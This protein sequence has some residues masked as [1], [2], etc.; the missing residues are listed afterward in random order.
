MNTES[1]G[2]NWITYQPW[3]DTVQDY[4]TGGLGLL[5]WLPGCTVVLGTLSSC[6]NRFRA[7]IK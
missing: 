1:R 5:D 2:L 6:L 7:E 3:G 4:K